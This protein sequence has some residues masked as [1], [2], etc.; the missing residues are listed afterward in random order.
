MAHPN[1]VD[2]GKSQTDARLDLIPI[3]DAGTEFAPQIARGLLYEVYKGGVRVLRSRGHA[4]T[5]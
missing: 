3:F 2:V 5:M 1:V 4:Q